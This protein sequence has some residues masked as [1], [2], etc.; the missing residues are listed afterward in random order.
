MEVDLV[1]EGSWGNWAIEV[2]TGAFHARE[3]EG[4]LE[5]CRRNKGFR[6]LVLCDPQFAA[7]KKL[8]VIPLMS[9][10]DFLWNGLAGKQSL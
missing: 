6:P 2:K 8:G 3:I 4:L 7:A 5:F 10:Q 1:V 9:W